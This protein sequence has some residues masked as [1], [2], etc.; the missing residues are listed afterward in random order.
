M[1]EPD[2]NMDSFCLPEE[3][4]EIRWMAEIEPVLQNLDLLDDDTIAEILGQDQNLW[5]DL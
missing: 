1:M 4:E 3:Q 5:M 2:A